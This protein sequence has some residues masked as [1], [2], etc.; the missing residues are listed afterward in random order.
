MSN[1]HLMVVDHG[2]QV[3]SREGIGLEEYW[4]GGEGG[5]GVLEMLED[6]IISRRASGQ[7]SNLH[8]RFVSG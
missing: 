1:T 5:M 4:V 8:A 3:V 7:P 6:E 2:S